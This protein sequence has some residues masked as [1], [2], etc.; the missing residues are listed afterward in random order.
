METGVRRFEATVVVLQRFVKLPE[1]IVELCPMDQTVAVSVRTGFVGVAGNNV[2]PIG[3]R[4]FPALQSFVRLGPFGEQ[5]GVLGLWRGASAVFGNG[6]LPVLGV[7]VQITDAGH[8]R[9]VLLE[10]SVEGRLLTEDVIGGC[11]FCPGRGNFLRR[12]ALAV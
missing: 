11:E 8:R 6:P 7:R 3:E 4:F 9:R 12:K 1:P 2:A 10:Q 5:V